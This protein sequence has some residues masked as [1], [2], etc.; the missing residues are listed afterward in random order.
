MVEDLT[1]VNLKVFQ[2]TFVNK[3]VCGHHIM[4]LNVER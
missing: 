1:S 4:C 3:T 2:Q